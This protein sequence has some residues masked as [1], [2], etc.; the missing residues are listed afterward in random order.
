MLITTRSGKFA[1][2]VTELT[3]SVS[4]IFLDKEPCYYRPFISR[5]DI[6]AG[7]GFTTSDGV[8]EGMADD[9]PRCTANPRSAHDI[10][11]RKLMA[12]G[13]AAALGT[14]AATASASVAAKDDS[15]ASNDTVEPTDV[16][17]DANCAVC[18][19]V[20]AKFPDWNAQLAHED[21]TRVYFCTPGCLTTYY[22]V[23]EQFDGPDEPIVGAW[24]H[25]FETRDLIDALQASFVLETDPDRVDDPMRLNPLPF[26]DESDAT[27]YVEQYDDLDDDTV[28]PIDEFDLD[29]AEL[30][31][32]QLLDENESD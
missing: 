8:W 10:H 14:T 12:L 20:P 22:V 30:Y 9:D 3:G 4:G 21:S 13:A 5:F 25:D 15:D 26:V 19:M 18:N 17:A 23:P 31:R 32:G 24:V 28:I 1:P 16:P 2:V 11:R 7:V 29:I 6:I 27:A